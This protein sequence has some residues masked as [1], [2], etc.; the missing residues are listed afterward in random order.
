M[1]E[2]IRDDTRQTNT[3]TSTCN[4]G[5]VLSRSTRS[6][7]SRLNELVKLLRIP[8]GIKKRL[9]T[10]RRC[11]KHKLALVSAARKSRKLTPSVTGRNAREAECLL[12]GNAL[13]QYLTDT[14]GRRGNPSHLTPAPLKR[15]Q[16]IGAAMRLTREA[17]NGKVLA[18]DIPAVNT[19]VGVSGTEEHM[20]VMRDYQVD[21]HMKL[22]ESEENR[23]HMSAFINFENEAEGWD[24]LEEYDPSY[25]ETPTP[26][27]SGVTSQHTKDPRARNML[28]P[29]RHTRRGVRHERR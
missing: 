5:S 16:L 29:P 8:I 3:P 4:Y 7:L 2:P 18:P 12:E 15:R 26:Q 10:N 19:Q 20:H 21:L 11:S 1:G 22:V 17:A 6:G 24:T 9:R 25:Q 14:A 23:A 13:L 28:Y 27:G